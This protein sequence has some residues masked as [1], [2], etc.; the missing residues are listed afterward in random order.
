MWT[1]VHADRKAPERPTVTDADRVALYRTMSFGTGTYKLEGDKAAFTYDTSS[2]QTWTS[3]T[4]V[5]SLP[6][7]SGKTMKVKTAVFKN[8]VTN[9][10]VFTVTTY[11]RLE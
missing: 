1:N 10:D 9:V 6:E 7:I 8:P 3:T 2:N 5:T 11:E 4:R